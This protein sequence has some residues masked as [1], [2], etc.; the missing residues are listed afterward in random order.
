MEQLLKKKRLIALLGFLGAFITIIFFHELVKEIVKKETFIDKVRVSVILPHSDDGYWSNVEK[1][2]TDTAEIYQD[3]MDVKIYIP[4]LNYNT[5]QMT[6]LIKQQVAAQ[7]DA[8][9]VQGIDDSDYRKALIKAWNKGIQVIFVDTDLEGFPSH[10]YVGTDNYA[11]GVLLGEKLIEITGG[12]SKVAIL[13]GASNYSNLEERCLGLY[14]STQAFPDIEYVRLDYDNYDGLTVI[15]KYKEIHTENPEIDTLICIE[16]TG[17]Q[18]LGT[19][20]DEKQIEYSHIL[21]FDDSEL[22]RQGIQ[23]G[24]LEGVI[25]QA[26]WEMGKRTIDEAIRYSKTGKYSSNC[27]NTSLRWVTL[28][29]IQEEKANEK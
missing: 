22:A 29:D 6:E 15:N 25:A 20:F 4:Q 26:T 28:K 12:V 11:A 5:S 19:V 21:A 3:E 27:I 1:G 24:V 18:T 13:S 17:G 14:N 9:I 10:L 7:V 8:I 16:G 23:N 2:I